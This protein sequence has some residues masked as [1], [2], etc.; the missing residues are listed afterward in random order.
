[1][2]KGAHVEANV[3]EGFRNPKGL[4]KWQ[5]IE[6]SCGVNSTSKRHIPNL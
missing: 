5:Q 3:K 6:I 1:V 2:E 4:A